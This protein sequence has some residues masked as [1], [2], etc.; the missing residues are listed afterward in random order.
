LERAI[1]THKY[2]DGKY[3]ENI[4]ILDNKI[5]NTTS[6]AIRIINWL[7]PVIK[8]N[9]I[10]SINGGNSA[11][12][13]ILASGVTHPIISEN[14]FIEVGKPIQIKP[15]KNTGSGSNYAITYNVINK[16]DIALMQRNYLVRVGEN[17]IRVNNTYNEFKYDTNKY[18]YTNEFITY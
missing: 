10:K 5:E 14:T 2:S 6:D 3:H 1:G 9:E 7:N 11:D 15:W 18:Y 4:Q 13:A 8:G 17:F 16:Q 12:C